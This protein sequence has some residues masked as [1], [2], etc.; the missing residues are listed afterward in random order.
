MA[1]AQR[2]KGATGGCQCGSYFHTGSGAANA[3][4]PL[5]P[6]LTCGAWRALQQRDG[7][8]G[9]LSLE[10]NVT[11]SDTKGGGLPRFGGEP[12]KLAEYFWHV[13]AR[14]TREAL[15]PEEE[16][17]KLGPLGLRLVEGLSGSASLIFSHAHSSDST[18]PECQESQHATS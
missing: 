5:W 18:C 14:S 11:S 7:I 10:D 16:Q 3:P 6:S 17:E 8:A 1:Q 4:G 13:R 12:Q 15:L 2:A 9:E